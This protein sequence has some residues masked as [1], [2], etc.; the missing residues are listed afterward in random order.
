MGYFSVSSLASGTIA[1][2]KKKGY[3]YS[4]QR[5]RGRR[6]C[7][8]WL[9]GKIVSL[10]LHTSDV[11]RCEGS[12]RADRGRRALPAP[13]CVRDLY[14]SVISKLQE[15]DHSSVV[16]VR[17]FVWLSAM[18]FGAL[19]FTFWHSTYWNLYRPTN[20]QWLIFF[21]GALLYSHKPMLSW[22]DVLAKHL[23]L[24]RIGVYKWVI[25]GNSMSRFGSKSTCFP[26]SIII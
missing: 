15:K 10:C 14:M 21:S 18:E 5:R 1:T 19:S 6:R 25:H 8:R 26:D 23:K 17:W 2:P 12:G 20:Q 4:R 9:K 24:F 13:R 22:T 11:P 7:Q 3:C 16:H